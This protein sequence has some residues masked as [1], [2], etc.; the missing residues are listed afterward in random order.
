[1]YSHD[2]QR[3]NGFYNKTTRLSSVLHFIVLFFR[4]NFL[5]VEMLL[6]Q[7]SQMRHCSCNAVLCLIGCLFIQLCP[8]AVYLQYV[9][10]YC[11]QTQLKSTE[12]W[13]ILCIGCYMTAAHMLRMYKRCFSA[14]TYSID[15][16]T[17]LYIPQLCFI[18][19]T[20]F[21]KHVLGV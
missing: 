5:L 2:G 4:C 21:L 1:M 8:E 6:D 9:Q 14:E 16:H 20:K 19:E 15:L 7:L 3:G 18:W 12:V 10:S 11:P 13:W 17:V